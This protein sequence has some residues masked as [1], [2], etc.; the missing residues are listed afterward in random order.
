MAFIHQF[1]KP[2]AIY[3]DLYLWSG[4]KAWAELCGVEVEQLIGA[5]IEDFVHADSLKTI[6]SYDKRRI[7]GDTAV[8]DRYQVAFRHKSGGKIGLYLA[9][10]PLIRPAGT[11]LAVAEKT[12]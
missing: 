11:W 4:N 12:G 6:I 7:Q 5:G 10:S 2:A 9:V 8:P 3:K 1:H